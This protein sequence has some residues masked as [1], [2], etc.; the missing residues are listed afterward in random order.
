[1][2]ICEFDRYHL[3]FVYVMV[4]GVIRL[5]LA[6]IADLD[7]VGQNPSDSGPEIAWTVT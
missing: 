4:G 5:L 2:P 3:E 7:A 6:A 1:M